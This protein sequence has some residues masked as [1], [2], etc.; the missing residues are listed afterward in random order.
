MKKHFNYDYFSSDWEIRK[1]ANT[2]HREIVSVVKDSESQICVY[3]YEY[4]N[5]EEDY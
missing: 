3:Y 4:I 5:D 2:G 1:F